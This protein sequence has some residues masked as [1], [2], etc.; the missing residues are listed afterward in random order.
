MRYPR[1]RPTNASAILAAIEE[2]QAGGST[3]GA[4]GIQLAYK[5][6]E[7]NFVEGGINRVIL[8]TDGDFN[9]GVTNRSD[10]VDLITEK[11]KHDVFLTVLGFGIGNLKGMRRWSNWPIEAMVTMPISIHC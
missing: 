9:V 4:A 6:A 11:A 7:E 5:I 8:C 3:N 10:L 1:H 2:M